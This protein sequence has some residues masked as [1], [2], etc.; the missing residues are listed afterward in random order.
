MWTKH[1]KKRKLGRFVMPL[2]AVAFLSYF[3]Y[4]SIHGEFGLKATDKFD[5]QRIERQARLDELTEQ[6]KTLEKEVALLSDGSLE[7]DM[8]DEKARFGLNMSRADEIVIFH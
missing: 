2:I 5:R 7:R 8:L 6:R 3:G 4:H 1:H